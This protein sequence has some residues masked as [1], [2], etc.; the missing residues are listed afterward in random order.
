MNVVIPLTN[1]LSLTYQGAA[2]GRLSNKAMSPI[3]PGIHF[4]RWL[5]SSRVP[6]QIPIPFTV[7]V[8]NESSVNSLF[9]NKD[10]YVEHN[11]VMVEDQQVRDELVR[12]CLQQCVTG[13]SPISM[14]PEPIRNR[15]VAVIKHSDPELHGQERYTNT[16]E[17]LLPLAYQA[18]VLNACDHKTDSF[19]L[20]QN[21]IRSKG[22]KPHVYRV[23]WRANGCTSGEVRAVL[24]ARSQGHFSAYQPP[25][26]P[27][28]TRSTSPTS[29][30]SPP[31]LDRRKSQML[32]ASLLTQRD[33][34]GVISRSR[35]DETVLREAAE[36]VNNTPNLF[37][38]KEMLYYKPVGKMQQLQ[39]K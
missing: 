7:V 12:S 35:L 26:A 29:S 11:A 20:L 32:V 25:P 36:R 28:K 4:F 39:D 23:E 37:S 6:L 1:V 18:H 14:H 15:F 17:L 31:K 34:K 22:D 8:G 21:Y 24:I 33:H 13:S 2:E 30:P 38:S 9:T 16:T 19:C 10:G 5:W 3:K 27:E